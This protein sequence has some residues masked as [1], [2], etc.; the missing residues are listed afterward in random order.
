M[1]YYV[2][3]RRAKHISKALTVAGSDSGGGAGIQ[4]DLKTFSALGVYGTS[5]I[6]SVTA[7]NT[8]GVTGI[9]NIQLAIIEKQLSAVLTD[10]GTDAVKTGMLSRSGIIRVVAKILTKYKVA[11]LVID[12]VMISKS[13]AKLLQKN[14]VQTLIR[15]LFP[16][17]YIVTPNIPE[18]EILTGM[19]IRSVED[20]EQACRIIRC[21]GCRAVVVKGGHLE[22]DATDVLFDGKKFYYFESKRIRTRNTHGTG[23]TFSAAL[24]AYLAKGF[25]LV[26]SVKISKKFITGAIAH[27][28][29][30][31]KGHGPVNPFHALKF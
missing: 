22:G 25:D 10:I 20:M 23:C 26:D 31:G 14:A 7:Q 12:P 11:R 9:Q 4:A 21:M 29:E 19:K 3:I 24:T 16:M 2:L 1:T 15:E 6:T 17:A 28:F 8:T 30:I 27:A 18:A 13:G 5:V